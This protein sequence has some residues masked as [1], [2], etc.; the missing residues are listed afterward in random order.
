MPSL[1]KHHSAEVTKLLFLG[2][3]G[4]GKTG[5]LASLAKAGYNL[6]IVDLDNGVDILYNLLKDDEEALSRVVYETIT[7]KFKMQKGRPLP[8]AK[9]WTKVTQLLSH[10]KVEGEGGYDLGTLET[11]TPKD[12]LVIDSVT[13]LAKAA[14]R[15]ILSIS[16]RLGQ[17]PYQSDYGDAQRLVEDLFATL[18]GSDVNCNVI[19]ISHITYIEDQ[20]IG[21]K[22]HPTTIGKAL[23]P[24]LP[25]YFNSMLMAKSSGQGATSKKLIHTKPIAAVELK[26]TNPKVVK[27]SYPLETGLAEYFAALR[28]NPAAGTAVTAKA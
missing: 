16:G 21:T 6:R 12:V 24:Q 4:S 13:F 14:F 26:T 8:E 28:G 2:E 15:H 10:W 18:Y 22:G 5:A 20:Y 17:S 7:D 19:G 3:S 27:D 1:A 23:S 9:V 11:W 25:R